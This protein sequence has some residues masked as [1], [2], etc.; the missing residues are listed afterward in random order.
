MAE[1]HIQSAIQKDNTGR[2]R[3]GCL[4]M[5]IILVVAIVAG[6]TFLLP[7]FIDG[8]GFADT[9]DVNNPTAFDPVA[10]Y[11]EVL[12]FVRDGALDIEGIRLVSVRASFVRSDGTL[13]LTASSYSPSVTYE[14]YR[15]TSP[16]ADA[17]P[18][19]AG[20]STSDNLY[21]E[22]VS[23]RVYEPGQWRS[24]TQVG[25]GARLSYTYMNRGMDRD[26]DP[27]SGSLPDFISAPSCSF[28]DLWA[29]AI[30]QDAPANAVAVI[31]YDDNGYRFRINDLD[32]SL[33]FNSNCQL[34]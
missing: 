13:D 34:Q 26:I 11:G 10:H 17:P 24:V 12:D 23:I 19:G 14:F 27:A 20:G 3:L 7:L 29:V 6:V 21:Y 28:A 33:R 25:N 18:V 16:P 9:R 31:N 30:E 32:I 1:V 2:R 4:L 22:D 15:E 5:L 8:F